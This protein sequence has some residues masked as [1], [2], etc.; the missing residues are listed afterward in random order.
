MEDTLSQNADFHS[1]TMHSNLYSSFL[2]SDQSWLDFPV[3]WSFVSTDASF[4]IYSSWILISLVGNWCQDHCS[5]VQ[6]HSYFLVELFWNGN[7]LSGDGLLNRVWPGWC[8][9][10]VALCCFSCWWRCCSP[11]G[12]A[13][14]SLDHGFSSGLCVLHFRCQRCFERRTRRCSRQ[15]GQNLAVIEGETQLCVCFD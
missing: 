15:L 6:R 4:P 8:L 11:L 13:I 5:W 12:V 10:V 2:I 7:C 9:K 3:W 1:W 14:P